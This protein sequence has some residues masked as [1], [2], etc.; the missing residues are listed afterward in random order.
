MEP[1]KNLS[2]E[3]M[4]GEVWKDIPGWEGYYQISNLGRAKSCKRTT[5][6][7]HG[8]VHY[9]EERIRRVSPSGP[10]RAYLG[11]GSLRE[12]KQGR[13]YIHK[14]VALAFIPNPEGKPCLDH[15]NANTYDNRVENLR[16]VTQS[17]NMRNPITAKRIGQ[18]KSGENCFFYGKRLRAKPVV[19]IHQDGTR[20]RFDSISDASKAGYCERS[21]YC[22]IKGEYSHHKGCKWEFAMP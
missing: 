1:Y 14:A 20:E 22:C 15:I 4:P 12:G 21:I 9:V 10:T 18:A 2:L 11:F 17:E 13:I 8:R 3:D 5:I 6:P 16:W 19:C 7:K